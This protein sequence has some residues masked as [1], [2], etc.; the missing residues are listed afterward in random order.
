MVDPTPQ[1]DYDYD[2]DVTEQH[3]HPKEEDLFYQPQE[4]EV[5]EVERDSDD[6]VADKGAADGVPIVG[7]PFTGGPRDTSLLSSYAKH[8]AMAIWYNTSNVSVFILL[9]FYLIYYW[10]SKF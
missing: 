5:D 4:E 1:Y 10:F 3:Y 7:P 6:E 2:Y 8:V 9:T